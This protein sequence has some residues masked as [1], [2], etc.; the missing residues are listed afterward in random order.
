VLI[1]SRYVHITSELL[2]WS[3]SVQRP[4]RG[5]E[6]H[7]FETPLDNAQTHTTNSLIHLHCRKKEKTFRTNC[8]SW[9]K[10]AP[11]RQPIFHDASNF[12]SHPTM[13]TIHISTHAYDAQVCSLSSSSSRQYITLNIP[14]I[15]VFVSASASS[16]HS[17]LDTHSTHYTHSTQYT[18][19]YTCRPQLDCAAV[20]ASGRGAV[21]CCAIVFEFTSV[22]HTLICRS[23]NAADTHHRVWLLGFSSG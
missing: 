18:H 19:S 21:E 9:K 3:I 1:S 12:P 11:P 17:W 23:H 6:I 8:S 20:H 2:L 7:Q 4:S 16:P 13:Y 10:I 5:I 14:H 22:T 15:I